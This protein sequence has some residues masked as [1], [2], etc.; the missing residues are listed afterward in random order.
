MPQ[1]QHYH[2]HDNS[3]IYRVTEV[4]EYARLDPQYLI[5]WNVKHAV[6]RAKRYAQLFQ[7]NYSGEA[8]FAVEQATKNCINAGREE[9]QNAGRIGTLSHL[10]FDEI[11]ACD[12]YNYLHDGYSDEEHVSAF[13]AAQSFKS[14]M[15]SMKPEILKSECRMVDEVNHFGGTPDAMGYVDGALT[16]LD[17]KT[18]NHFSPSYLLQV[19]AYSY[20][21]EL[22]YGFRPAQA[23][24]VKLDKSE[25]APDFKIKVYKR[26]QLDAGIE[27]FFACL[28]LV[29]T[30]DKF[31]F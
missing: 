11:I 2:S 13:R 14:F 20:L 4:I 18:S 1:A 15:L 30:I 10:M 6:E 27:M 25:N 8:N 19:A 9:M 21:S 17:W 7:N 29:K 16:L 24:V 31:N 12:E 3:K 28:N 23:I 26:E 22:K 5:E